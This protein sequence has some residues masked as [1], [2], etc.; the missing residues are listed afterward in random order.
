MIKA[1]EFPNRT[2]SSIDELFKALKTNESKLID[3]KKSQVYKSSEKGQVSFLNGEKVFSGTE[4]KNFRAKSDYIYPIISTTNYMDSHKD[5]HFPGCFNKTMREQEGKVKYVLD[6]DLKWDSILAWQKDVKMFKSNVDWALV[7]KN[8]EGETEALIFEIK[9]SNIIRKDVLQAI[10]EGVE[11]F[12]NSIRMVYHKI[13]LGINSKDK[14]YADN[15]EYYDSRINSIANKDA[16]NK[17]GYFWG[18]EELGIYKEGSL[19]VSGGSNDATSIFSKIE[20]GND[21]TSNKEEPEESTQENQ[22][23]Y[24]TGL[25]N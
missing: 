11:E 8:Y 4:N 12:E 6:H 19:V 23:S 20:A 24:F 21:S 2:F 18:V 17:N 3:L 16:V 5:V 9:K 14:D 22:K 1:I 15:K 10:E 7:G 13:Y 25:I